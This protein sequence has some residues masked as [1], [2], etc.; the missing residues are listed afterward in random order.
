MRGVTH[1]AVGANVVWI[2]TLLGSTVAPWLIAVAAFAALLPDLD[3]SDSKIKHLKF[4]GYIGKSKVTFK[5]FVPIAIMMSTLFRHRGVLHSMLILAVLSVALL[6]LP[7]LT[8]D[9]WWIVMMAYASH[10]ALDAL[11]KSGIE[12]FWPMKVRVGLLPKPLRVKTGGM[13]DMILLLLGTMGVVLYL[14][15][16]RPEIAL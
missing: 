14:Y 3:A 8:N 6:F 9:L 1:A 7:F 2:P 10:L 5:P 15:S 11:T 12:A 4:G 13:L 16:I